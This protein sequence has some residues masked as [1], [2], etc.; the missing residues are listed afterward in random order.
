MVEAEA[1]THL[2][3]RA[4]VAWAHLPNGSNEPVDA[5]HL[6]VRPTRNVQLSASSLE[7]LR[8]TDNVV[9]T[10]VANFFTIKSSRTKKRPRGRTDCH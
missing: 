10:A 7:N 9:T 1:E 2:L 3:R 6:A 4:S 8:D 5:L